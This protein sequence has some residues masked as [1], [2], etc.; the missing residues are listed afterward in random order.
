MNKKIII[1]LSAVIIFAAAILA[2]RVFTNTEAHDYRTFV[3]PQDAVVYTDE[4]SI[5]MLKSETYYSLKDMERQEVYIVGEELNADFWFNENATEH[6]LD[7]ARSFSLTRFALKSGKGTFLGPGPYGEILFD[8]TA[9]WNRVDCRIY[10]GDKL[11]YH[12]A[13]NEKGQLIKP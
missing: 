11:V 1:C 7:N 3:I 13:Y 8:K 4:E 10:V 6:Q 5:E 12:D 9:S 2:V